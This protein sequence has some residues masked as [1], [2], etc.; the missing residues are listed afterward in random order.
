[1]VDTLNPTPVTFSFI[2]PVR[3]DA[4]GLRRC[5]QSIACSKLPADRREVIVADNGSD[6]GTVDVANAA[7]ARVLHLPALRVSGLRNRAASV[8]TGRVLAFVDAD[9]E[10][11][12]SWP[13]SAWDQLSANGVGAVG[14]PCTSPRPGSWVQRMYDTFRDHRPGIREAAWLGSGNLAVTRE[15]FTSLRGFDETLET[16]EDVDFCQR[17]RRAGYRVLSDAR[18]VSVHH[19][20]PASLGSLFRS[21]LWRGRDNLRV[22]L[23][24]DLSVRE[25]PSVLIPIVQ[26]VCLGV[27]VIAGATLSRTGLT[28]ALAAIAIVGSLSALRAVVMWTRLRQRKVFDFVRAFAVAVVYDIA[29][30]LALTVQVSHRRST[31]PVVAEV[32]RS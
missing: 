21:E 14:A 32:R 13:V 15:A 6:D 10:I 1:L 26:L 11:V 30:A 2:I 5:L 12:E 20:D 3:N 4:A 16:C 9:H 31:P 23:R 17:L 18:L 19:G 25:L 8:A 27:I 24:G 22:S 7:G 28:I 29:R